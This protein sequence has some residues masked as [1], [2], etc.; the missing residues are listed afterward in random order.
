MADKTPES[1][2]RGTDRADRRKNSRS[3]RRATDPRVN[4]RRLTWVF[5][6]YALYLSI[7]SFPE[8]VRRLFRRTEA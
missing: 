4:W 3:G 6:G 5:A 7:R 1:D 2:R 8:A